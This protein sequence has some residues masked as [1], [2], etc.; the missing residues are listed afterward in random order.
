MARAHD[1]LEV[2]NADIDKRSSV[3]TVFESMSLLDESRMGGGGV[4]GKDPLCVPPRSDR[5]G[6]GRPE[7]PPDME[8]IE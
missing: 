6:S 8:N 2:D 3:A 4:R 7:P 1:T 5:E